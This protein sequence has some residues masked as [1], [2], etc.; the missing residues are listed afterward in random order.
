[1]TPVT[2]SC[3]LTTPELRK[4]KATVLASLKRQVIEKFELENG[5][6]FK[7][8]GTDNVL[9]ELAEFVKTERVCC[10]FFL[11]KLSINGDK[12]ETWLELTGPEGAKEFIDS[13]LG[14]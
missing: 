12:S 8:P 14:L 1:M 6:S 7:F 10:P 5:Y 4:R 2:L 13:E 3:Q 11:F 9:D